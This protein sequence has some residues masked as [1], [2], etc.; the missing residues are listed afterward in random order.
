MN[1]VLGIWGEVVSFS[2]D[3]TEPIRIND[4]NELSNANEIENGDEE[5][6]FLVG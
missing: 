6:S 3:G 5:E 1:V 4:S 2:G